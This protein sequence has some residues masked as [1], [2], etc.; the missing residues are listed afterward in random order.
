[1]RVF[2]CMALAMCALLLGCAAQS[3]GGRWNVNVSDGRSWRSIQ[4][5]PPGLT[6]LPGQG[7]RMT[8]VWVRATIGG[9]P[10]A[11]VHA[12]RLG[13]SSARFARNMEQCGAVVQ[14]PP[15]S[16]PPPNLIS[17][18]ERRAEAQRLFQNAFELFQRG[19]FAAAFAGFSSGLRYGYQPANAPANFYLA[20]ILMRQGLYRDAAFRYATA[21]HLA[22]SSSEG[23]QAR[24]RLANF[25]REP[26]GSLSPEVVANIERHT[27]VY[28]VTDR[29]NR[30][31]NCGFPTGRGFFTGDLVMIGASGAQ[32]DRLTA[33]YD[34][35]VATWDWRADCAG[36]GGNALNP[37]NGDA[38][39]P[40]MWDHVNSQNFL[41]LL[42]DNAH[43][44][45][46]DDRR[47]FREQGILRQ[48]E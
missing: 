20:E 19:D 22:P 28:N 14:C 8:T 24:A 29:L 44:F 32:I 18:P 6:P 35:E 42:Y 39:I 2:R 30:F 17:T 13:E 37:S 36:Y 33:A 25:G 15:S 45:S 31:K 4:D 34:R 7:E 43:N 46:E 40:R 10:A 47:R 1:M 21:M 23:L 48:G 38:A 41:S 16:P 26:D 27:W 3:G 9:R 11:L 12:E 5:R